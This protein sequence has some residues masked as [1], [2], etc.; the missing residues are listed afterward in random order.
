MVGLFSKGIKGAK[1]LAKIGDLDK[2][3]AAYL[4]R[5][6][7]RVKEA[8]TP[9]GKKLA[10]EKLMQK[11]GEALASG[12]HKYAVKNAP[13]PRIRSNRPA[14]DQMGGSNWRKKQGLQHGGK[15]TKRPMGGKVYK[16]DNSGQQ[17]VAKQ[18]GG[19][20]K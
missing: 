8:K 9:K 1:E 2:K 17:M 18:Y 6:T 14:A 13:D 10:K 5:L 20:V 12:A 11:Q 19:K 16:V 3:A 15:L 4:K 7:Q